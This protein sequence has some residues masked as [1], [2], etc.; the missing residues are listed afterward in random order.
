MTTITI[1]ERFKN[2]LYKMGAANY[3]KARIKVTPAR[4]PVVNG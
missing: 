4:R 2:E 1:A 3:N